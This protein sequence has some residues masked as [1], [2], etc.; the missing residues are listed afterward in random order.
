MIRCLFG[1]RRF[2]RIVP[3]LITAIA[4]LGFCLVSSI[5][6]P[7][8][9][10]D[11]EPTRVLKGHVGDV[12]LATISPNG[13]TLASAGFVTKNDRTVKLWDVATGRERAALVEPLP[14]VTL[15]FSPDGKC[16]A[17][18]CREYDA[19]HGARAAL[20]IWDVGSGRKERILR[21]PR[22]RW[23]GAP[24]AFSP[25]GKTLASE[26][27][28]RVYLWDI[29]SW[30]I[31]TEFNAGMSWLN[32]L[33]FSPD[34]HTIATSDYDD[35]THPVRQEHPISLWNPETGQLKTSLKG[36]TGAVYSMAFSPNGKYLASAGADKTVRIWYLSTNEIIKTFTL[37]GGPNSV[38][39]SPNGSFLA[40]GRMK[41]AVTIW[42]AFTFEERIS[43]KPHPGAVCSI[44]F[45]P[46]EKLLGT[47]GDGRDKETVKFWSLSDLLRS[48]SLDA[49]END[50]R[51][52]NSS[53]PANQR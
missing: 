15:E 6:Q 10:Q 31:R 53:M 11:P 50:G 22:Y 37:L 20:S 23:V 34:G 4:P 29:A 2:R 21:N 18:V 25:D 47:S 1:V 49:N 44:F 46:N 41:G 16:L 9:A 13:R 52:A 27:L 8:L 39:Y 24:L 51:P 35:P 45:S 40:A 38:C 30:S 36:A 33:A 17:V 7:T 26:R 43:F 5:G 3:Q 12:V 32:C 42:D 19:R 28:G 48:R 14:I